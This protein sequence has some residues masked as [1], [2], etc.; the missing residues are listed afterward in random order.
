[1]T[2]VAKASARFAVVAMASGF[3][4]ACSLSDEAGA[5]SLDAGEDVTSPALDAGAP[6]TANDQSFPPDVASEALAPEASFEASAPDGSAPFDATSPVDA[7]DSSVVCPP[8][9]SLVTLTGPLTADTA[10]TCDHVYRVTGMLLVLAPYTLTIQQGTTLYMQST[11]SVVVVPG[12]KI[13]ARGTA[14]QPI[15]FTSDKTS[16]PHAG[17][18]GALGIFGRAPGNW[19]LDLYGDV[20]TQSVP[21]G[22]DWPGANYPDGGAIMGGGSV[23]DDSSGILQYVRLEYGGCPVRDSNN[24]DACINDDNRETLGL[25][26]VGAGT[27]L[28]HVDIRQG[29]N[30]CVFAEGGNFGMSH[31][32][33]QSHGSSGA[34]DFTRGNQS[35]AQFLV[36]QET[37]LGKGEGIGFKG[38]QDDNQL[39]PL[40]APTI[41]NATLCGGGSGGTTNG[42]LLVREPAGLIYDV[43]TTQFTAGAAMIQG[44]PTTHGMGLAT[45]QVRSSIFNANTF[46]LGY[47]LP[48]NNTDMPTWLMNS[49]WLNATTDPG[50]TNSCLDASTLRMAPPK[51][52]TTN[53]AP[54]PADGFFDPSATYV[55]AFRDAN[56]NWASGRWVVW[57]PN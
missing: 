30:G 56:D 13:V 36:D 7:G 2:W 48:R 55:G 29:L 9:G 12:A 15:V 54:P 39:E 6:D 33:C 27:L 3:V 32:V 51:S 40:T 14:D 45:T 21:Q 31:V 46:N 5:T 50:I 35:R 57:S 4:C 19:G 37:A 42:L 8:E 24:N 20:I 11:A 17:D 44:I 47:P 41:Y 10:L 38:P 43:V 52:L 49:D 28:D 16:S 34:F 23:I 25:Y 1:M 53:A 26:G 22:A 18:W